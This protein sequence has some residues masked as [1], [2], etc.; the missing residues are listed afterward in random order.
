[1][2][3]VALA[4]RLA[5]A[6]DRYPIYLGPLLV[7]FALGISASPTLAWVAGVLLALLTLNKLLPRLA[8]RR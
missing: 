6:R 4:E 8:G 7:L 1:M 3:R 5:V 2:D